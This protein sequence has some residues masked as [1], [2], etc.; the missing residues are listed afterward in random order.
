MPILLGVQIDAGRADGLGQAVSFQDDDPH[1]P[2][3]VAQT[4]P[5]G[6]AP[7]DRVAGVGAQQ[8]PDGAV[9]ETVGQGVGGHQPGGGTLG[10]VQGPGVLDGD[11]GGPAEGLELHAA[12]CLGIGGVVDLLQDAGNRQDVGGGEG[13]QVGQK[14]SDVRGVSEHAVARQRQDLEEPRI[15]VRQGQ[16]EQKAG[17]GGQK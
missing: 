17:A 9:D 4:R 11:L 6:A 12:A 2:V 14:R 5:Q 7:G 16:E 8:G 10:G 1:A 13:S 3:E 15:G